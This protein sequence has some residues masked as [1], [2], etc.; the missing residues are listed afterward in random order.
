MLRHS[1]IIG[2]AVWRL[3]CYHALGS[4]SATQHPYQLGEMLLV[5]FLKPMGITRYRLAKDIGVVPRRINKI[6]HGKRAISFDTALRLSRYF[7]MTDTFWSN[8]QAH[9]DLEV[10]KDRLGDRLEKEV[11]VH[12]KP[13]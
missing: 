4:K 6:V 1:R 5:E 12:E 13:A 8:L 3:F 7:G 11:V 10:E 9:N 2:V